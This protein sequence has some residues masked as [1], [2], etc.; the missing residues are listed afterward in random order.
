MRF[1][2]NFNFH[3]LSDIT[4]FSDPYTIQYQNNIEYKKKSQ[5]SMHT[6]FP[7]P[8]NRFQKI[9]YLPLQRI[10]LSNIVGMSNF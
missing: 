9:P 1:W 3:Y 7:M 6:Y 4:E 2:L 8:P 10:N 5:R